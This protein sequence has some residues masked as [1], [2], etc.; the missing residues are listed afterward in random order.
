M[1][2]LNSL[3]FYNILVFLLDCAYKLY[4]P[5]LIPEY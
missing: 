1:K 5:E 3:F 4:F 2:Y